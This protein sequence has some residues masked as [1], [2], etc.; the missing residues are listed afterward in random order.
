MNTHVQYLS[1]IWA[2]QDADPLPIQ[3]IHCTCSGSNFRKMVIVNGDSD[4]NFDS[5]F[6]FRVAPS[7]WFLNC[8]VLI[9]RSFFSTVL[10][11]YCSFI[12]IGPELQSF[13][14]K[15]LRLYCSFF[16]TDPNLWSSP[17]GQSWNDQVLLLQDSPGTVMFPFRTVSELW[18][19]FIRTV[20]EVLFCF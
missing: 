4:S 8:G 2:G 9:P 15:N 14:R 10:E 17:P 20:P 6:S 12:R 7:R 19:S 11:L 5:K 16:N 13:F 1:P 3:G 18:S